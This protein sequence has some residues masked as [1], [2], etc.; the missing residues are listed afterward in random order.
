MRSLR[1]LLPLAVFVLIAAFL[2]GV[3]LVLSYSE[4]RVS[5]IDSG[6]R[7]APTINWGGQRS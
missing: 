4:P 5:D 6:D 3:W 1:F 7:Q 2:L